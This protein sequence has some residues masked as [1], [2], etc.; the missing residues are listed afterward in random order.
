M[1]QSH[2]VF[3]FFFLEQL[4]QNIQKSSRTKHFVCRTLTCDHRC[5]RDCN[6]YD[7]PTT[8][9]HYCDYYRGG[10]LSIVSG[11]GDASHLGT[12]EK[13][14]RSNPY[15]FADGKFQPPVNGGGLYFTCGICDHMY[16]SDCCF[17]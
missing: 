7:G 12:C 14:L 4:Q 15:P 6:G 16:C 3:C 8:G 2:Y 9:Y 1:L 11:Y 13:C 5:D 10:F 17:I